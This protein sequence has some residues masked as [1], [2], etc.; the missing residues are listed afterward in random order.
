LVVA[1]GDSVGAGADFGVGVG[2]G[3]GVAAAIGPGAG[4]ET[5]IGLLKF[6][7]F[8]VRVQY[9]VGPSKKRNSAGSSGIVPLS[10]TTIS[11]SVA[12]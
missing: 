6:A 9:V 11:M 7:T 1:V 8:F 12:I 10:N 2:V 4:V 3:Q 5:A